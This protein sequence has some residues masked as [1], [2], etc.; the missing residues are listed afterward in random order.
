MSPRCSLGLGGEYWYF[1]LAHKKGVKPIIE[2]ASVVAE[3][4]QKN[5]AS[6]TKFAKIRAEIES[7][8]KSHTAYSIQVTRM[9]LQGD[10]SLSPIVLSLLHLVQEEDEKWDPC[11]GLPASRERCGE[12]CPVKSCVVLLPVAVHC[13]VSSIRRIRSEHGRYLPPPLVV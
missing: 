6:S 9:G 8:K 13:C 3:L 5:H 11:A 4:M 10:S 12:L 7:T 2:R 1:S